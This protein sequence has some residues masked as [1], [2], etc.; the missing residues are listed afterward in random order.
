MTFLAPET[1]WLAL[2]LPKENWRI[3][4]PCWV[5]SHVSTKW[6]VF[7]YLNMTWRLRSPGSHSNLVYIPLKGNRFVRHCRLTFEL[8]S[9]FREI[10]KKKNTAISSD[11]QYVLGHRSCKKK[12]TIDPHAV[13]PPSK[14]SKR[15]TDFYL[16]LSSYMPLEA[17]LTSHFCPVTRNNMADTY[18]WGQSA[19]Q[20]RILKYIW[21]F[22]LLVLSLIFISVSKA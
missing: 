10:W 12:N 7:T 9:N 19:A 14:L 1:F 6:S 16:I 22:I 4:L 21:K 3:I 13:A 5:F 11:L 18:L 8:G 20:C 17:T 15:Y 2:L